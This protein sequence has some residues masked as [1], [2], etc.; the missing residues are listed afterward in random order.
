[1]NALRYSFEEAWVSLRRRPRASLTAVITIAAAMAIPGGFTV[2]MRNANRVMAG[3]EQSAE[4][5]VFLRNDVTP[6]QVS[7]LEQ[8]IDASGIASRRTFVSQGEALRRFRND[9]PDLGAAAA[10]LEQNPLPASIE[11]RLDPG[12]ARQEEVETLV[13]RL[14]RLPGVADVRADRTWLA[15]ILSLMR[16]VRALAITIAG[17]LAIAAAFTVANVVRLAAVARTQEIEIM[18]LVG[19]PAAYVRGP[20]VAEGVI[21]GGAG[22]VLAVVL[23]GFA[24]LGLQLRY[25]PVLTDTLGLPGVSFMTPLLAVGLIVGGMAIGCLGGYIAARGVRT[26]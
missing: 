7:A 15:R 2:A 10:S 13:T 20:F 22:A 14:I 23:L 26:T 1:M 19:A 9:F 8:A 3:W 18:Q 6:R 25:A 16:M 4:L 21:Q 17:L 11:A 12:R 24:L 5:S